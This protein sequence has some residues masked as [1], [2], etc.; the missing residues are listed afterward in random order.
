MIIVFEGLDGSG[1]ETQTKLIEK[2]L[3]D[4]GLKTIRIEFPNYCNKYSLF[5]KE[6][7]NGDFG[8]NLNPYLISTF[9]D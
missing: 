5:V 8:N 9:L 4:I 7:L 2:R 6:Y 3:N 1:K